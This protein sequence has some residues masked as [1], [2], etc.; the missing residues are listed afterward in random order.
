MGAQFT[1]FG[2][3]ASIGILMIVAA[4]VIHILPDLWKKKPVK[5][6]PYLELPLILAGSAGLLGAHI[7]GY[8]A[9]GLVNSVITALVDWI[10]GIVPAVATVVL[11]AAA[12]VSIA[13]FVH[14]AIK[15]D[16][17]TRAMVAA[18][19]IPLTIGSI[20]GSFGAFWVKVF[21]WMCTVLVWA[22]VHGFGV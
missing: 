10:G 20:P 1:A 6:V 13:V 9:G 19:A 3:S 16:P 12:I 17:K 15:C 11:V 7:F 2:V 4:V 18:V 21:G 8:S 14:D 5:W 22:F